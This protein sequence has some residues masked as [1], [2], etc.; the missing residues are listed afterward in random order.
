M[1]END[2]PKDEADFKKTFHVFMRT[3]FMVEDL[4]RDMKI[5]RYTLIYHASLITLLCGFICYKC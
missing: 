5:M 4:K 1:T 3:I 2:Q